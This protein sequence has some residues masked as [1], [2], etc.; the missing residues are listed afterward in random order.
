M[1]GNAVRGPRCVSQLT[2]S[3]ARSKFI[4]KPESSMVLSLV[5]W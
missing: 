2:R 5:E 3:L 1:R 4:L